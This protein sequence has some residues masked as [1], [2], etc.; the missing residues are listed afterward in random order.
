VTVS[1][2]E[3]GRAPDQRKRAPFS[4]AGVIW[5][6]LAVAGLT[7]LAWPRPTA[8]WGPPALALDPDAVARVLREDA[9]RAAR[10]PRDD[11]AYAALRTVDADRMR[12]EGEPQQ[13][14]AADR[15]FRESMSRLAELARRHGEGDDDRVLDAVRADAVARFVAVWTG[16]E[17]DP[18]EA[19][20]VLGRFREHLIGYGAVDDDG[21]TVA[22]PFVVRVLYAARWNGAHGLAPTRGFRPVETRAY[23]GW[24]ALHGDFAPLED[25][26]AAA[27]ALDEAGTPLPPAARAPLL[28]WSGVLDQAT[29]A[30]LAA[31]EATGALRYRNH[32]LATTARAVE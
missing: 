21:R 16:E 7:V 28:A 12:L 32:A 4:P 19:R 30:Y 26:L 27:Q 9:E 29:E 24:L 6:V 15:R 10:V 23:L 14:S 11:P 20:A 17:E 18:E 2:D 31:Y 25:R 5:V 1:M 22:P 3:E 8:P 13:P